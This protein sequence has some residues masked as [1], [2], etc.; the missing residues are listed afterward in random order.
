MYTKEGSFNTAYVCD[1]DVIY[2]YYYHVCTAHILVRSGQYYP[3]KNITELYIVYQYSRHTGNSLTLT[4]LR[5]TYIANC[6]LTQRLQLRHP[7]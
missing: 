3:F 7:T 1:D 5:G 4:S 2:N 6:S